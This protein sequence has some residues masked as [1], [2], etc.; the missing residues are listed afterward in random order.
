MRQQKRI[1]RFI[2]RPWISAIFAFILF[3]V[4]GYIVFGWWGNTFWI[5]IVIGFFTMAAITSTIRFFVYKKPSIEPD[6]TTRYFTDEVQ[7]YIPAE[8]PTLKP[9]IEQKIEEQSR[10]CSFCGALLKPGSKF[11]PNCGAT[12]PD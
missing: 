9:S 2:I 8:D 4:L 11:C 10:Y 1:Y 6:H 7:E 3:Y 5:W 12:I